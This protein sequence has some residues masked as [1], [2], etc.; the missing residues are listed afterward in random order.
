MLRDANGQDIHIPI[1]DLDEL[2]ASKVSLMP[3]NVMAQL[4]YDQFIDLVAFLKNRAAQES[5]RGCRWIST[6]PGLM[7][8]T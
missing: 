5:L 2:V 8:A 4:S 1:K 6:W 3:D 7:P